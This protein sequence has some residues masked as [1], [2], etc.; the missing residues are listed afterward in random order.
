MRVFLLALALARSGVCERPDYPSAQR[1]HLTRSCASSSACSLTAD[2]RALRRAARRAARTRA[3]ILM[4][5]GCRRASRER[6]CRNVSAQKLSRSRKGLAYDVYVDVLTEFG[7]NCPGRHVPR[8]GV[9]RVGRRD[10]MAHRAAQ[11]ADDGARPV[12]TGRQSGEAV[13]DRESRIERGGFRAARAERRR[14]SS[15]KPMPASPA[16]SS[17]GAAR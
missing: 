7:R 15:P 17:S 4:R 2:A 1:R 3:G 9:S 12:S 10:G 11:R 13:P 8:P 16:S 14:R 6:W 5:S